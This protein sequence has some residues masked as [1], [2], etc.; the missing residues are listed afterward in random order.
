MAGITQ[1]LSQSEN[2]PKVPGDQPWTVWDHAG[3]SSYTQ[4]TPGSPPTGGQVIS[5][6][7]MGLPTNVVWAQSMGSDDGQYDIVCMLSPFNPGMPSATGLILK[8]VNA[9]TGAEVAGA[10]DLSGRTVRLMGIGR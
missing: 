1:V 8:W 3:P 5:C 9:A 10:T 6:A 2:F 7:K 4:V